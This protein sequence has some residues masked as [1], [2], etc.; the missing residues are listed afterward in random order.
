MTVE[1]MQDDRDYEMPVGMNSAWVGVD[2]FSV[3]IRRTDEGLVVDI[4]Q[5]NKEM[6]G[7]IASTYAYTGELEVEDAV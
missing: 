2:G 6:D 4:F 5:K 3:Y 7:S 1:M